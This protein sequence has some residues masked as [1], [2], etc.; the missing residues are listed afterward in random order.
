MNRRRTS[1]SP[2]RLAAI[3]SRVPMA[4]LLAEDIP[5]QR[6]GRE[7]VALCPFHSE[8]SPSCR[9]YPDGHA[10][11]FGCGWHGD[12]I[13]WLMEYR[14]LGFLGAVQHLQSWG[15]SLIPLASI[16]TSSRDSPTAN[17][18]PSARSRPMLLN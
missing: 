13:R 11:C 6:A 12:V 7:Y 17:G 9:I 18:V 2:D 8:R 15:V 16:S 14:R 1:I 10:Y 5:L 3:K 4:A